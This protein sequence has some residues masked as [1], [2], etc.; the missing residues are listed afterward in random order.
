MKLKP[1][2]IDKKSVLNNIRGMS[3]A[4]KWHMLSTLITSQPVYDDKTN[5]LIGYSKPFIKLTKEEFI[6]LLNL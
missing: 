6:R 1:N 5:E 2:S 4:G 3:A